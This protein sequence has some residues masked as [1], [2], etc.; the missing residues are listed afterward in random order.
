MTM[1]PPPTALYAVAAARDR[2]RLQLAA[3]PVGGPLGHF[4]P[5]RT[6]IAASGSLQQLRRR[7][8]WASTFVASLELA[9]HGDAAVA[10]EAFLRP[11]HV[12][13]ATSSVGTR[14]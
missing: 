5:D 9:K 10:Q 8:A 13:A 12:G 2:I 14:E 1:R 11:I 3:A 6:D 7:S 4:L